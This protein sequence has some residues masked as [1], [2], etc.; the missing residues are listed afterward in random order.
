[1]RRAL[2]SLWRAAR[3][4]QRVDGASMMHPHRAGAPPLYAQVSDRLHKG[5]CGSV[6]PITGPKT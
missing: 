4:A 5:I 1:M 2:P 3:L 6:I